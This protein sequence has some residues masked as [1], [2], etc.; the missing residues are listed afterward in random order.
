MALCQSTY[1]ELDTIMLLVDELHAD[2]NMSD[3]QGNTALSLAVNTQ[4]LATVRFIISEC[5]DV[6]HVDKNGDTAMML[7][8]T[9]R[10]LSIEKLVILQCLKDAQANTRVRNRQNEM[11]LTKIREGFDLHGPERGQA[12]SLVLEARSSFVPCASDL[13]SN[14]F[15]TRGTPGISSLFSSV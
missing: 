1:D 15:L 9:S 7:V 2:I 8:C 13:V 11:V 12:F 5:S 10:R 6:N 3:D 14:G 4:T